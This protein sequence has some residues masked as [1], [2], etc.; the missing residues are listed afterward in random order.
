[1]REFCDSKMIYSLIEEG[2]QLT[3]LATLANKTKIPKKH[4]ELVMEILNYKS[5]C[6]E[7]RLKVKKRLF[8]DNLEVFLPFLVKL[9]AVGIG[10]T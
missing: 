7:Y 4:L 1:M 6:K 9:I 8:R 10:F 3:D 5:S 2:K